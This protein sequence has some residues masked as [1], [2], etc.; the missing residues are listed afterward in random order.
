MVHVY[1]YDVV[2]QQ[3]S[4]FCIHLLR[5]LCSFV[6]LVGLVLVLNTVRCEAGGLRTELRSGRE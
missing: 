2:Y 6:L 4:L 5:V 3:F 1:N